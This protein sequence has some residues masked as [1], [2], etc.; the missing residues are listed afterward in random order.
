MI[1]P[2]TDIYLFEKINY[3][4]GDGDRVMETKKDLPPTFHYNYSSPTF[5]VTLERPEVEEYSTLSCYE[6]I[7]YTLSID[8]NDL[9]RIPKYINSF[10]SVAY[11]ETPVALQFN[12]EDSFLYDR[13]RTT[14]TVYLTPG[15]SLISEPTVHYY[16][17][18]LSYTVSFFGKETGHR[19]EVHGKWEGTYVKY[20]SGQITIHPIE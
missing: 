3:Y 4:I 2:E 15:A 8:E 11:R 5:P 14:E 13:S 16:D 1:T 19:I 7:P 17:M 12:R 6:S 10:G 9:I 18:S 20:I